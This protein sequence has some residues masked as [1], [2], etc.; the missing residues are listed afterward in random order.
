MTELWIP[1]IILFFIFIFSVVAV[2]TKNIMKAIVYLS[3]GSILASVMFVV[4]KAPDVAM[5]EAAI[6]AGI[7]TFLFLMAYKKIKKRE[8]K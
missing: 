2:E 1:S 4:W 6:G 5:T 8:S 3:G 7:T